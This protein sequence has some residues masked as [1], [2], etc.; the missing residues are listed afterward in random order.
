MKL[1]VIGPW[2]GYPKVNGASAGYLLE[3]EGFHL[4]VDC[5][6]AVLSKLQQYINPEQLDAVIISHYHPDH[7]ADIGVLQ[8]ALIIGK[9]MDKNIKTLPIY[10]HNEDAHG[11]QSLFFDDVTKGVPYGESDK[12]SI[13]PFKVTF[14]RTKHPVPCFAMRIE[15]GDSIFVFTADSSYLESFSPF[16]A[17]ADI[18]LCESN[19]YG[20]M[21]GS[22]AGHM[23]SYEAGEIAR[24]AQVKNL[25]LTHLP[26][27]GDLNRLKSE[28]AEKFSGNIFVAEEGLVIDL[29]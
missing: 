6:S 3:H 17:N 19:F 29:I 4:L 22:A 26:Q 1:T 8:H 27:Y 23:T 13:G 21:D 12:V 20:D 11:F 24:A 18:L 16:A 7:I 2:G 25:I 14:L 10:G 15:A 5:G 28:A 9:Y